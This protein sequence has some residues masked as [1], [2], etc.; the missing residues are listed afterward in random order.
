MNGLVPSYFLIFALCSFSI[1]NLLLR[2]FMYIQILKAI[3]R[4]GRLFGYNLLPGFN[5]SDR[6]I[7]FNKL[8]NARA[9]VNFSEEEACDTN[10]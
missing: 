3:I 9:R 10:R 7:A 2:V 8:S 4:V 5:F 6:F 1:I